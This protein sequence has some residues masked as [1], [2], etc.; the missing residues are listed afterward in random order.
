MSAKELTYGFGVNPIQS[1]NHFYVLIPKLNTET[2]QVFERFN[3]TEAEEQKMEKSDI[4]RIEISKHKW[5]K[6]SADL[7]TEFNSRL[8]KDKIKM[9]KF[10]VGGTAVEKLF[11]KELMVLLWSIEDCDPSVIPT[12]I[13]NW[14][15]L[16]PEERWWLYTMTN[17]ST[18][19]IKDKKGWRIALRYALCEN[20][21]EENPQSSIFDMLDE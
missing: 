21:I 5:N 17:A 7:T 11:G 19:H 9:G 18:G 8:K 16:M 6:I 3:W 13:R 2:V 15:G 10:S 1:T 4:L 20:P 12:A 14:K